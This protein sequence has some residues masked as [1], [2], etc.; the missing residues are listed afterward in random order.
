MYGHITLSTSYCNFDILLDFSFKVFEI[1]R[2]ISH[3]L[4]VCGTH[5]ISRAP[6]PAVACAPRVDS[7]TLEPQAGAKQAVGASL[8]PPRPLPAAD[9]SLQTLASQTR[10]IS[11]SAPSDGPETDRSSLSP[12]GLQLV[13]SGLALNANPTHK[14]GGSR[15]SPGAT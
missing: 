12:Y 6:L 5:S 10:G 3:L 1:C 8:F 2:V 9:R 4:H 11:L 15:H 14:A 7:A 13:G